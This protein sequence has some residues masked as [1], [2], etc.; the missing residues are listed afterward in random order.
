MTRKTVIG[1]CIVAAALLSSGTPRDVLAHLVLLDDEGGPHD[2]VTNCEDV[3][4]RNGIPHHRA[5]LA[6][7]SSGNNIRGDGSH[8]TD[9][10]GMCDGIYCSFMINWECVG[11]YIGP[12][13]PDCSPNLAVRQ[14]LKRAVNEDDVVAL[15]A[16]A[17]A[18]PDH[19]EI[20]VERSA[21]QIASCSGDIIA[22]YPASERLVLRPI[23]ILP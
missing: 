10:A 20:S 15:R 14:E 23:N 11:D 13:H 17:A 22:F 7:G 18:W 5:P 19:I 6:Q 3:G 12:K 8:V 16:L 2:C 21:V 9:Y 4:E 1:A